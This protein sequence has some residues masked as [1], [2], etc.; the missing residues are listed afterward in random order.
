MIPKA[1]DPS[2]HLALAR[3][4]RGSSRLDKKLLGEYISAPDRLELLQSFIRLFDFSGVSRLACL[5]VLTAEEIYRGCDEGT[6]GNF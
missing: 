4:L 2:Y 3:F 1:S 6:S 5:A